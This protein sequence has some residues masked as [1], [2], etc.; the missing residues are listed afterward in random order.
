MV[1][2]SVC[3]SLDPAG[4]ALERDVCVRGEVENMLQNASICA[5]MF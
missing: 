1:G 4:G 2:L 3:K 5:V